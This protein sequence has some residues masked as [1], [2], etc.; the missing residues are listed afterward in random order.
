MV[1]LDTNEVEVSRKPPADGYGSTETFGLG[2][3][4]TVEALPGV[5]VAVRD[6]LPELDPAPEP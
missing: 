2:E 3:T 6:C 4:L 1:R 5:T